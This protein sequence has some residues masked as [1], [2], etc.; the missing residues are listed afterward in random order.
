[1]CDHVQRRISLKI[2]MRQLIKKKTKEIK[3]RGSYWHQEKEKVDETN[4]VNDMP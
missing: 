2:E 4:I 1:M 3:M